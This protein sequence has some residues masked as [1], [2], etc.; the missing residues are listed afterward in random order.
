MAFFFKMSIREL[1]VKKKTWTM[2]TLK[3]FEHPQ[4]PTWLN[5]NGKGNYS[6]WAICKISKLSFTSIGF[7]LIFVFKTLFFIYLR[8][9]SCVND[10][11]D[12][13]KEYPIFHNT[14][15]TTFQWTCHHHHELLHV[16]KLFRHYTLYSS[17]TCTNFSNTV[18]IFSLS[19]GNHLWF[20]VD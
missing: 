15:K 7:L 6:S 18:Y 14:F 10:Y 1:L 5:P 20:S 9:I 13:M 17:Y 2:I 12:Q 8:L 11:F 19:L 4:K 16:H 3:T